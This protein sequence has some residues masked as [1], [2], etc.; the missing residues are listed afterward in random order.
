MNVVEPKLAELK[1]GDV[2]M[3]TCR[4]I[5]TIVARTTDHI[6]IDKKRQLDNSGYLIDDIG[7]R[8]TSIPA[9]FKPFSGQFPDLDTIER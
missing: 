1:V 4:E 9:F 5:V 8:L 2:L 6:V 7:S 3:S